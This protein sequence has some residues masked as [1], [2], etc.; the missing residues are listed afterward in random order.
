M[1]F[2]NRTACINHY[3][4]QFPN[5]PRYMIEMALDYDLQHGG[6]S[7]EKPKTSKE[8]RQLKK[9]QK[10]QVPITREINKTIQHALA[11]GEFLEI[12]SAKVVKAEDYVMPPMMKGAINVDGALFK[13]K[14]E[15]EPQV[16]VVEDDADTFLIHRDEDDANEESTEM[17]RKFTLN[18]E[19]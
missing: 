9:T 10:D 6:S 7:N 14:L 15:P 5:L 8:K 2:A 3:Q 12:D 13:S 18:D 4:D 16:E 11:N 19:F 1:E 17:E